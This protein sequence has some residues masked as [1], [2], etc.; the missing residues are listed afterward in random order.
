MNGAM[1]NVCR[2]LM[3]V[4]IGCSDSLIHTYIE[5]AYVGVIG[6]KSD[7]RSHSQGSIG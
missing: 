4:P 7:K 6:A 3:T 1:T 5:R 2:S